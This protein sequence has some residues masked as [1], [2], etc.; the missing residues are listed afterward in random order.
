M[1]LALVLAATPKIAVLDARTGP[2]V[3]PALGPYLA[4][5]LAKEVESRTGAAPLL[6]ADVT[7]MLGFERNKRMLG[8]SEEDSE[9]LAEIT[10]ALGVAQVLA[11]SVAISSGRYLVS[12]SLLDSRHARPLKR[13]AESAPVDHDALV[14]VVRRSAWQIFGGPEPAAIAPA[15]PRS[16]GPSRRTLAL[17]AGGGALL[18]A[19]TGAIVGAN[20]LSQARD[21]S[22][23]ALSRAHLADAL[24][25]TALVLAGTGAYLWFSNPTP[26]S[27]AV[28][29]AGAAAVVAGAW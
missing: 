27:V 12:I 20:A 13:T 8:C 5:V 22:P 15:E 26:V 18:L 28:V 19:G 6:S 14:L 25:G 23:T 21:N 24:F 16:S 11:S 17:V 4:Q 7:A 9:C 10:G 2:G 3:D 29:P 1:L